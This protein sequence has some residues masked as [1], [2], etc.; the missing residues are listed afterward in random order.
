MRVMIA[1]V[2]VHQEKSMHRLTD[3]AM[4]NVDFMSVCFYCLCICVDIDFGKL[5]I[6]VFS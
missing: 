2:K 6:V 5:L 3:S 1:M 4:L